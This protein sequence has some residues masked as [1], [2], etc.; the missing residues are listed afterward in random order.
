MG[1]SFPQDAGVRA[2]SC[3]RMQGCR[4]QPPPGC[5]GAGM[6]CPR[7]QECGHCLLPG[8]RGTGTV[9]PQDT[10]EQARASP[11]TQGSRHLPPPGCRGAGVC[12]QL[13]AFLSH[14][15]KAPMSSPNTCFEDLLRP[16]KATCTF[17]SS[18]AFGSGRPEGLC[19]PSAAWVEPEFGFSGDLGR[20]WLGGL[21]L[22]SGL[23]DSGEASRTRSG[24]CWDSE[25]PPAS[26]SPSRS[27]MD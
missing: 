17:K 6:S 15:F 25:P 14:L 8:C 11:R 4:H 9:L 27:G 20:G 10:G 18:C 7:M 13:A 19:R 12:V 23:R 24:Q 26:P 22:K 3:P 5:R 2:P 16:L 21:M 1:T